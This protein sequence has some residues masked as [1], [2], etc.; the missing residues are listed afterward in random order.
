MGSQNDVTVSDGSEIVVT[1]SS[2]EYSWSGGRDGQKHLAY[3]VTVT[4]TSGG[5]PAEGVL[6]EATL[7][8]ISGDGTFGPCPF[9][10]TTGADGAV[11]FKLIG[12]GDIGGCYDLTVDAVS[13]GGFTWDNGQVTEAEVC[14]A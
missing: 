4:R 3:T 13:G 9:A 5:S 14:K 6:V 7:A 8:R 1:V 2:I 11:T 10:G 12:A